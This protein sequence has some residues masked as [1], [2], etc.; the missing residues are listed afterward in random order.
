[1]AR[2]RGSVWLSHLP[3]SAQ[4]AS[5]VTGDREIIEKKLWLKGWVS[6]SEPSSPG[7]LSKLCHRQHCRRATC[8]PLC[9]WGKPALTLLPQLPAVW[10]GF[11]SSQITH[12]PP[13]HTQLVE[14]AQDMSM[15]FPG[16]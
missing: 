7:V 4:L 1:M 16:D 10:W 2:L 3:G 15:S 5:R 6:I 11:L 9:C 14:W 8:C 13:V 12:D